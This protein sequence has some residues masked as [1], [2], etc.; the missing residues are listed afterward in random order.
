MK[1]SVLGLVAVLVFPSMATANDDTK[2]IPK[3]KFKPGKSF[4]IQLPELGMSSRLKGKK[5]VEM[6]IHIP[7]NYAPDRPH[8][9]IA[10]MGGGYGSIGQSE[11]WFKCLQK[12][13]FIVFAVDYSSPVVRDPEFKNTLYGLDLL[14]RSTTVDTKWPQG[15]VCHQR[16]QG[17]TGRSKAS[18]EES[19]LASLAYR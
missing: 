17:G 4:T 1:M 13:N 18:R 2:I 8:P 9:V 11:R 16:C 19:G 6:L 7:V 10:F 15:G 12:R 14:A 5:P 3:D